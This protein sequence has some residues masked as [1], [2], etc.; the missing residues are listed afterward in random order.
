MGVQ[1]PRNTSSQGVSPAFAKQAF[2]K[3]SAHEGRLQ[4][5]QALELGDLVYIPGHV[6]LSLGQWQGQPWVIHDVL[7][8]SYHKADGS[9]AHVKLNA[10]SVTPLLPMLAGKDSTFIDHMTSIVRMRP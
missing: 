9:T 10:V 6:M 3:G 1:M 7:G 4:A 8:M 2:A 5:A